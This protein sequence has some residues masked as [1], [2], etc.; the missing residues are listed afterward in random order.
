MAQPL[1]DDCANRNSRGLRYSAASCRLRENMFER[2]RDGHPERACSHQGEALHAF[3]HCPY[4]G[5]EDGAFCPDWR[6]AG[7]QIWLDPELTLTHVD[8]GRS[9]TGRI[10]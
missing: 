2:L 8:G 6:A 5:G 1:C 10:G 7:G 9:F 4:G 3:F